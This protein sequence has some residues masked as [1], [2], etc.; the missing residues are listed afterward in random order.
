MS[1]GRHVRIV[2][3][4]KGNLIPRGAHYTHPLTSLW[5]GRRKALTEAETP[6]IF[7]IARDDIMVEVGAAIHLTECP[8]VCPNP[9]SGTV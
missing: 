9:I 4:D 1:T 6:S 3:N 5:Q 8:K 2:A 7:T